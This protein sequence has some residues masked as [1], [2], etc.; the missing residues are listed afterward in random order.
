M[1]QE[2]EKANFQD[3]RL[4]E[5]FEQIKSEE[6]SKWEEER[7]KLLQE[8]AAKVR[9]V[10]EFQEVLE[11]R[12]KQESLSEK[13]QKESK[14]KIYCLERDLEQHNK[15]YHQHLRKLQELKI[16]KKLLKK[17]FQRKEERLLQLEN[18]YRESQKEMQQLRNLN[19]EQ[20]FD[21]H[22]LIR[23]RPNQNQLTQEKIMEK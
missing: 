6:A 20:K 14:K 10:A 5:K 8:L 12:E 3:M 13:G 1:K 19:D 16:K 15:L 9:L 22:L 7:G 2:L 18:K 4:Q 23:S 21:V 11:C 17:R